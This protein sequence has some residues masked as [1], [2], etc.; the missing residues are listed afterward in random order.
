MN[1]K[2]LPFLIIAGLVL[3]GAIG[4]NIFSSQNELPKVSN[5]DSK[6]EMVVEKKPD[7]VATNT[8]DIIIEDYDKPLTDFPPT[9]EDI[10]EQREKASNLMSFA[11]QYKT[12]DK[13]IEGLKAM[14][15]GGNHKSANDLLEYIRKVYPNATI[16]KELLD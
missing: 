14:R 6:V 3:V 8:Q 7:P 4:W 15:A 16:P 10:K 13:A 12:A 11:L 2:A 9:E 5:D 1:S